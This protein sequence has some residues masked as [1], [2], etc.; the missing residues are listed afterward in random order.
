MNARTIALL[1]VA[2]VAAALP[3]DLIAGAEPVEPPVPTVLTATEDEVK[4][5]LDAVAR[6]KEEKSDE[7]LA[8]A[9]LDMET[10]RHDSFVPIIEENLDH[11]DTQV[12]VRALRAAASHQMEGVTKDVLKILKKS[13]K[14]KKGKKKGE[15]DVSG[16]IA[17]A[18]IDF[19][20]RMAVEGVEEEVFEHMERLYLVES[21]MQA[22]YAPDLMRGAIHYLGQMKYKPAVPKFVE[23]I[24]EPYPENPNSPSNPPASYWESRYKIWQASEGWLRWGLKEITGQEYRTHREWQAWLAANEKEYK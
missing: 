9:L 19:V 22:E 24:K 4:L 1:G 8:A 17:A 11:S 21:R 23:L 18:A 16:Y 20:A 2:I 13:K 3:S 15:G 14:S 6:S 7:L 5:L 10:R 12:Q